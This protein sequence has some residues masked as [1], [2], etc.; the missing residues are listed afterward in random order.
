LRHLSG[1]SDD[2]RMTW[3]EDRGL[4]RFG[5]LGFGIYWL[6]SAVIVADSIASA[7]ASGS[8]EPRCRRRTSS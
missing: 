3:S 5:L 4:V 2:L 7:I 1:G 6:R 8:A